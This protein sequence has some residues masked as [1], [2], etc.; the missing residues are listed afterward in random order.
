MV[1]S[2]AKGSIAANLADLGAKVL[3]FFEICK[4]ARAFFH[5]FICVCH[6]FIVTLQPQNFWGS[7]ES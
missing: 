6:F 4:P 2:R 3:L 5:L 7:N 1:K